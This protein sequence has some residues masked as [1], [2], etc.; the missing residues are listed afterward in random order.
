[1]WLTIDKSINISL[2][3]QV[4][5]QI[6]SMILDG[7]LLAG[8]K[9]P[10]T[11]WLS[12]N[13]EVS[14]NV[15]LEAYAQLTAEGY[16]ESIRGS[17]TIVAKGIYF[18]KSEIKVKKSLSSDDYKRYESDLIN[19]RSGIPALDMFP[20]K[21]WGSLYNKICSNVDYSAFRYCEPEG[22]MELRQALSEYL[23]RVRG[24]S[25]R[26]EQ[27]MI[28]SG[29]TQGLS[30]I[31]KLL[32]SPGVEIAVEDPVHYGLLNV[33]SSCGY[34][35]NPIPVDSKGIR[36]DM[37]KTDNKVGFVYVTPSHQFPL[38]GVL[39]I[40]RRIELIRFAE[41]KDCYIVE[42]D[43]DS[44][45]RYEGQPISSLYELEPNRV[46]YVGSFSKILAPALRLG[47]MIL[48]DLLIPK[49][50]KLKMYTD[51]HT[52]SISQFVLAQFINDGKLEKHIWKM[53]KEYCKKRQAVISSLSIN[54]PDEYVIKGYAAGLHLVAE[55]RNVS[56][57]EE[58]LEK[59]TQQKVKVY[60][61]E[62]YAVHKGRHSNK[63][64]LGYGH[65]SIEEITEGIKRIKKG[66][67]N[68]NRR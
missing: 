59:I 4:Y 2:I 26:P 51:V 13:L 62:K 10:S 47:Y 23:F 40:Q 52:E 27:I 38:G 32:Y 36:T 24:I 54:F 63:I 58:V 67:S 43:Y 25:C 66:I 19:F 35:I 39:P 8:N 1:M 17:G 45:F 56:F 60:P 42:D 7:K 61:V 18:K 20:Q 33:I 22:I 57:T 14:R 6:K 21:E 53:K 34:L 12:E 5:G 64:L 29:S 50:L 15:I 44:E 31:S 30:L 65:L 46:I 68:I 11:R 16:I 9:L 49:Y 37:L 48:P 41:K 55:F 28:I 3:R